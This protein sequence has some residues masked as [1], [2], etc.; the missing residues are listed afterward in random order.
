M[1]YRDPDLKDWEA[2]GRVTTGDE[3]PRAMARIARTRESNLQQRGDAI[4]REV[5]IDKPKTSSDGVR[6]AEVSY[7]FD[8]TRL[9]MINTETG[10]PVPKTLDDTLTSRVTMQLLPDGSW[11]A[12]AYESRPER[13]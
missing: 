10:E 13:C 7:C 2:L 11:R 6:T 1:Y 12:A 9:D 3:R 4:Y 8:P 5:V